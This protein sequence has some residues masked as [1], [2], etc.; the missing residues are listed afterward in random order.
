MKFSTCVCS[1]CFVYFYSEEIAFYQG[2]EREKKTM[3]ESFLRLV[4][5]FKPSLEIVYFS[6]IKLTLRGSAFKTKAYSV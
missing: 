6:T 1:Q 2:Q 4:N 3:R 5:K